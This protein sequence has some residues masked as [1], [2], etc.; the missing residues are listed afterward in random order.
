MHKKGPVIAIIGVSLII[1]SF[2]VATSILPTLNPTMNTNQVLTNLFGEMFDQM[3]EEIQI[4]PSEIA[5]FTYNSKSS[6]VPLLWGLQIIDFQK[7]DK[8]SVTIKNFLGEPLKTIK[9]NEPYLFEI[10][11]IPKTDIYNFEI[12]NL[13]ERPIIVMMMFSEDPDNSQAFSNPNSPLLNVLIP[14][15]ISGI[16]LVIGIIVTIVGVI[17]TIID[18]RR[19]KNQSKYI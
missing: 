15:A 3:T 18:W 6:N 16:I 1:I 14:L 11:R 7:A 19:G 8:Y 9:S 5:I 17:I 4:N 12:T 10:F 2:G 13:S